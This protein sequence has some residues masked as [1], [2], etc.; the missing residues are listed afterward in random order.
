VYWIALTLGFFGSLHCVG[1][2]GP[3]VLASYSL[4]RDSGLSVLTHAISYHSGRIGGYMALGLVF[5]LLGSVAVFTGSQRFLSV[6]LGAVLVLMSLFSVNPDQLLSRSAI[7]SALYT[8][9][10]KALSK[11]LA[12]TRSFPTVLS[13]FLNGFLPCGLVYI[14]I[15]GSVSM[16]HAFGAMGF[17]LFFGMGTIPALLLLSFGQQWVSSGIRVSLRRMYPIISFLMGLYLIYRG[18]FSKLPLELDFFEAVRNP[19]MCH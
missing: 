17:M 11:I 12:G 10:S 14:A 7:F 3:L 5:G 8:K 16:G 19:I 15:A 4:K 13:G 6:L 2:C 1:M 9:I 18:I